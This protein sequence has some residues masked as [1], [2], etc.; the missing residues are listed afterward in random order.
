[1]HPHLI[2]LLILLLVRS[3]HMSNALVERRFLTSP[4]RLYWQLVIGAMLTGAV[5]AAVYIYAATRVPAG[6]QN[7]PD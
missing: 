7:Q 2:L 5:W 3:L 1:V 6:N 4:K